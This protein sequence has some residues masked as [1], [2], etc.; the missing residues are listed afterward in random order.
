MVCV[1]ACCVYVCVVFVYAYICVVLVCMCVH[2]AHIHTLQT[3]SFSSTPDGTKLDMVSPEAGYDVI[4]KM[5]NGSMC[6]LSFQEHRNEDQ[7]EQQ[8]GYELM[9]PK[10]AVM[11]STINPTITPTTT[12]VTPNSQDTRE[13]REA[14]SRLDPNEVRGGERKMV[15]GFGLW[16]LNQ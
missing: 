12:K 3:P 11:A 6:L 10:C 4:R 9:I 2:T 1:C 8:N 14:L 7:D 13:N 15:G 16:S 5:D